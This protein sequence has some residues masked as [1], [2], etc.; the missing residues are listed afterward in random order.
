MLFSFVVLHVRLSFDCFSRT[1]LTAMSTDSRAA[2]CK[3]VRFAIPFLGNFLTDFKFVVC[4]VLRIAIV[5]FYVNHVIII[6]N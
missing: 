3:A 1:R 6:L 5:K 4:Q 2:L